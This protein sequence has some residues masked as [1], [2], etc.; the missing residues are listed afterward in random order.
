MR[1]VKSQCY[2]QLTPGHI[3]YSF[4]Q[5]LLSYLKRRRKG[6]RFHNSRPILGPL[7]IFTDK[8]KTNIRN[9]CSTSIYILPCPMVFAQVLYHVM[10]K[11]IPLVKVSLAQESTGPCRLYITCYNRQLY[12]NIR[13]TSGNRFKVLIRNKC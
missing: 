1:I 6:Y 5:K 8:V 2:L 11:H 3:H 10:Q 7:A 13:T 4:L 9:K 12:D